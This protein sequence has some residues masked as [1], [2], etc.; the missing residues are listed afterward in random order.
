MAVG[1][2]DHNRTSDQEWSVGVSPDRYECDLG[3]SWGSI[4]IS[5]Q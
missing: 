2:L 1:V 4:S 5:I 3:V